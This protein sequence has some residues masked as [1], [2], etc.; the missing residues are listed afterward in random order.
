[1]NH[2]NLRV[3]GEVSS[4]SVIL[5]TIAGWLPPLAAFCAICWY[6]VLFYDRF[7]KKK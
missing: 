5:A 2:D 4:V 7:K 1:M 6:G 3:V